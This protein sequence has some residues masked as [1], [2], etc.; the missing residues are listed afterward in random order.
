VRTVPL[1]PDF[2]DTKNRL[3]NT[4]RLLGSA[5][6]ELPGWFGNDS[7][8]LGLDGSVGRARSRYYEFLQ[9]PAQTY[10]AASPERGALN[11]RGRSTRAALAGFFHYAW[12]PSDVLRVTLG[13]RL[14]W[15]NDSFE[16]TAPSEPV[17]RSTDHLAFSPK[18]GLNLRLAE[19]ATHQSRVYANVARSFKAPTLDQLFDQRTI[20]V[21]FPPFEITFAN[22]ELKPQYGTSVEAGIFHGMSVTPSLSAELTLAAYHM[23]LRDELDFDLQTLSYKN[24]GRS[25]HRGIE[26]GIRVEAPLTLSGF[27]NYTLQAAT[28]ETGENDGK[29]LKAIPLHFVTAGIDA[30]RETGPSASLVMSSAQRIYLD[31]ANTLELPGWTRWDARLSWRIR[32]FQL[33]ADVFNLFDAEYST[34]AFPDPTDPA[35][36][37]HYPAAGRVLQVGIR[38]EW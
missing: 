12:E 19:S 9:G 1:A 15:L 22:H 18:A 28:S 8:L 3:L 29:Y 10:G 36:V 6:F 5:Q 17:D 20:P 21:P 32:T 25:Q 11:Q 34:T 13:G 2:A 16:A 31:D 24:I 37:Y 27:A 7:W 26:A 38:R 35:I 30:G 4:A 33:F 14:D 23:S